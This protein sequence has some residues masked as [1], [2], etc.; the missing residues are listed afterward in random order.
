MNKVLV[1]G[2]LGKINKKLYGNAETENVCCYFSLATTKYSNG[3]EYTDWIKC[4]AWSK[5]AKR[6]IELAENGLFI[7]V[8]GYIKNETYNDKENTFVIVERFELYKTTPRVNIN[9]EE[10]NAEEI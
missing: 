8:E 3:N 1:S 10:L 5:N 7:E 9:S 2:R 4:K 6:F